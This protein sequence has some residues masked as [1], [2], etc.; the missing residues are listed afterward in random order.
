MRSGT[1]DPAPSRLIPTGVG[2]FDDG[3]VFRGKLKSFHL[4][5][6]RL[7]MRGKFG[8]VGFGL[9]CI[10]KLRKTVRPFHISCGCFWNF[11]R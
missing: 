10:V 6:Y 8:I 7:L 9:L 2:R 3:D 11:A 1:K 5:L 4:S